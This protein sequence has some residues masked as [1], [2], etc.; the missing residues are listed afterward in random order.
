MVLSTLP[1]LPGRTFQVVGVVY[2]QEQ[3]RKI[4]QIIA[5]MV[6]QAQKMGANGIVNIQIT[7]CANQGM[8]EL[9]GIGTAVLIQ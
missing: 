6:Q 5:T 2:G 4:N 1:D 8:P 3:L 7:P 9:F